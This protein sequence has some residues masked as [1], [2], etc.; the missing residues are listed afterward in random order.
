MFWDFRCPDCEGTLQD[1]WFDSA[2]KR[3]DILPCK[4]RDCGGTMAVDLGGY[5]GGIDITNPNMYGKYHPGFDTV[6]TDY[7]HKQSLLKETG[8]QEAADSTK[9]SK[10]Y[11][12][13]DYSESNPDKGK[14]EKPAIHW[15]E[16][17]TL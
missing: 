1:Q 13:G 3:P 15:G 14:K 12:P 16:K 6:V 8:L 17:N 9:G 7:G 5:R 11:I 4:Q 10:C 2:K